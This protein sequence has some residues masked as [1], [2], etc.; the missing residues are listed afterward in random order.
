MRFEDALSAYWDAAYAE[1][2]SGAT[3]DTADGRAAQA[4]HDVLACLRIAVAAERERCA[5]LCDQQAS[6]C[7]DWDEGAGGDG[8]RV[9]ANMCAS[10]IRKD[11]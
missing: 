1:G 8:G 11:A 5:M 7:G 2:Q 10:A 4:L 3:F 6:D 9:A